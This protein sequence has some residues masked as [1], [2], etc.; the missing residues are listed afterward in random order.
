MRRC[1][2]WGAPGSGR[3]ACATLSAGGVRGGGDG[4]DLL[5][6]AD[7]EGDVFTF[8][9]GSGDWGADVVEGGDGLARDWF[10]FDYNRTDLSAV[11]VDFRTGTV[12]GGGTA[13]PSVTTSK[14]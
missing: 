11:T 4:N 14:L 6:G 3:S 7:G 1:G 10:N 8:G 2:G 5:L 13:S 12:S 9:L